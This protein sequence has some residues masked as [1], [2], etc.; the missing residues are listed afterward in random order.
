[1]SN[2][3]KKGVEFT[4]TQGVVETCDLK[5][6]NALQQ[7]D[8]IKLRNQLLKEM[9][10][11]NA[12]KGEEAFDLANHVSTLFY[13]MLKPGSEDRLFYQHTDMSRVLDA[14]LSALYGTYTL[15]KQMNDGKIY[16]LSEEEFSRVITDVTEGGEGYISPFWRD[17][18]ALLQYHC[19]RIT[20]ELYLI[21]LQEKYSGTTAASD[22]SSPNTQNGAESPS[23]SSLKMR[24]RAAA[25][26]IQE[27][28]KNPNE[29]LRAI[30]LPPSY[31]KQPRYNVVVG[32]RLPGYNDIRG[33]LDCAAKEV[34]AL[35]LE[36]AEK[37]RELFTL[38]F[39]NHVVGGCLTQADDCTKPYFNL[40]GDECAEVFVAGA[41]VKIYNEINSTYQCL[42]N[43]REPLNDEGVERL[44]AVFRA[45][46]E[47]SPEKNRLRIGFSFLLDLIN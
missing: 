44:M 39:A 5:V 35:K 43:L 30:P 26:T 24:T 16:S 36:D 37:R 10:S 4:N 3:V 12:K 8:A 33:A 13:A 9:G 19:F 20:G 18:D 46:P 7:M 17:M 40:G 25:P 28:P 27:K 38:G 1:M 15:H 41:S 22:T 45:L 23:E 21:S 31:F 11:P 42:P 32:I 34:D 6:L 2:L 47:D 29:P 14:C